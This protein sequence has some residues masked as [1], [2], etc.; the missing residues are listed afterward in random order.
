MPTHA[1]KQWIAQPVKNWPEEN[2]YN[3]KNISTSVITEATSYINTISSP[4]PMT[5]EYESQP[6][7]ILPNLDKDT[8]LDIFSD[9]NDFFNWSFAPNP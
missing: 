8:A 4:P 9:A 7:E 6:L 5:I 1:N 3:D 2:N